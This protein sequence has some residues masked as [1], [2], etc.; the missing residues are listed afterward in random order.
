MLCSPEEI[1]V[2]Y[3]GFDPRTPASI[4]LDTF[5]FRGDAGLPELIDCV[6]ERKGES[7]EI[8]VYS[9]PSSVGAEGDSVCALYNLRGWGGR[10]A[11]RGADIEPVAV[12]A[13]QTGHYDTAWAR[14]STLQ[15][16]KSILDASGFKIVRTHQYGK[17]TYGYHEIDSSPVREGHDVAFMQADLTRQ[18]N[19]DKKA[20]LVL[21]NNFLYWLNTDQATAALETIVPLVATAGIISF[22]KIIDRGMIMYTGTGE[23]TDYS[24]WVNNEAIPLLSEYG[25]VPLYNP[26]LAA[27][28]VFKKR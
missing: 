27:L 4:P 2:Q 23:E 13:A 3:R 24:S 5:L 15:K 25:V 1:E 9:M 10:I 20:D 22:G 14:F 19:V 18:L 17:N 28:T 12:R 8:T 7:A 21:V 11:L 26:G 16:Q 6:A